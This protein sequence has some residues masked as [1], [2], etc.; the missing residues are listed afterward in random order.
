[1][2]KGKETAAALRNDILAIKRERILAEAV[3]LFYEN[4]Y[5]P[6]NVETVAQ[7]LGATK[8]FVYYHFDSKI[9][10]L[11]EICR[12]VMEEALNAS[13]TAV[14]SEGTPTER[15]AWFVLLFTDLVLDRYK[16]TSIYFREELNLPPDVSAQI[17]V[18]RKRI[19]YG[20]REILNA[21]HAAGEFKYTNK[22]VA[23]QIISGMISY[24]FAWYSENSPLTK[25]AIRQ[26]LLEHVLRSVGADPDSV[27]TIVINYSSG[28][29]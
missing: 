1:M 15:L 20:L 3:D 6:T 29:T 14:H 19:D 11:S 17:M 5:L 9:S 27:Q 21:G 8:P 26:Q 7:Q 2:A 22:V 25:K 16:H 18:L 4:G 12:K 23:S 10:M 24:T 13:D 28:D